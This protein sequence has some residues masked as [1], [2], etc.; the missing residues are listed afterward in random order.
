MAGDLNSSSGAHFVCLLLNQF[1]WKKITVYS[2]SF[3]IYQ[4]SLASVNFTRAEKDTNIG[5]TETV[6]GDIMDT[7]FS[8]RTLLPFLSSCSF[9]PRYSF[10]SYSI[11]VHTRCLSPW[12]VSEGSLKW[13]TWDILFQ[14]PSRVKKTVPGVCY[15]QINAPPLFSL[16]LS[17]PQAVFFSSWFLLYLSPHPLDFSLFLSIPPVLRIVE[18]Q[19]KS[20]KQDL[21]N[22]P[23]TNV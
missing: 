17:P 21:I 23:N 14:R 8:P 15:L 19:H 20:H 22:T 10:P 2:I 6:M 18:L 16:S 9:L 3:Y 11:C 13:V 7:D 4:G 12:R 1:R 5:P